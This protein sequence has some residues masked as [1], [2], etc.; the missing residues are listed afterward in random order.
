M[1]RV[2][3]LFFY[4]ITALSILLASVVTN[5]VVTD[6]IAQRVETDA[7]RINVSGRQRMLSQRIIYL[8]MSL[9][10]DPDD[11]TRA[12]LTR[13]IRE[14]E[15]GIDQF[16]QAHDALSRAPSLEASLAALYFAADDGPTL[17]ARVRDYVR[18]ARNVAQ[19][20]ADTASLAALQRIEQAGLLDDL[21]SI[22]AQ[23]E[24]ISVAQ[25]DRMRRVEHASL[26]IAALIVVVEICFVFLPGHRMIRRTLGDLQARNDELDRS[27]Q[28][29]EDKVLALQDS[30]DHAARESARLAASLVQSETLRREQAEFTYAVSHDLKSPTNTVRMVLDE[31]ELEKG[32]ELGRDMRDMLAH[33]QATI[34][35]M[36]TKIE[37]ILA[38]AWSTG[39]RDEAET[40]DLAACARRALDDLDGDIRATGASVEIGNLGTVWGYHK[41][42]CALLQNLLSNSLKYQPEGARPVVRISCA[43]IDG[44]DHMLLEVV[45]NGIGIEPRHHD[46]IFGLFQRLHLQEDYSGSGLGLSTCLRIAQNHGG[47]IQVVS[48][49]G[50]G[51]TFRVA[52]RLSAPD[53]GGPDRPADADQDTPAEEQRAA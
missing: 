23:V 18:L 10:D 40:V 9:A 14:F 38:Y 28:N 25:L 33:A 16:A 3:R 37:D 46:R 50:A 4:Y 17:D 35:R 26:V 11:R 43:G 52:L 42:L 27:R 36:G 32:S 19:T 12:E 30:N 45:D 22:V 31:L 47:D 2:D 49:P 53:A 34:R 51:A 44:S 39:I 24:A 21:D 20:P 1:Q 41:Q 8:A 7:T 15:A 48:A 13:T 29:V 6:L 5:L